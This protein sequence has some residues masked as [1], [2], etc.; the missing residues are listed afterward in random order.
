MRTLLAGLGLVALAGCASQP[1]HVKELVHVVCPAVEPQL[2]CPMIDMDAR[3]VHPFQ[4]QGAYLHAIDALS[5]KDTLL[6]LW[7]TTYMDCATPE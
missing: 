6:R 1:R 5:C 3:P 7:Q 2:L 4:L